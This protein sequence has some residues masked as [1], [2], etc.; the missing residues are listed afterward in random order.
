MGTSSVANNSGT[1]DASCNRIVKAKFASLVCQISTNNHG[2]DAPLLEL[3]LQ[4]PEELSPLENLSQL[5][6][7]LRA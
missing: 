1:A 2:D 3:K 6:D 7:K 4:N 5:I